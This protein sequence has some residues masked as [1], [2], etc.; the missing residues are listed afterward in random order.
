MTSSKRIKLIKKITK[1]LEKE[2]YGMID[3]TFRQFN[4]PTSETFNATKREYITHNVEDAEEHILIDLAS[5]LNATLGGSESEIKTTFWKEGFLRLFIS[6]LASDKLNAKLL[7][8]KLANYGITSFVAHPDIEPTKQWQEQIELRLRTCDALAALMVN[9]FHKSNWADQEI[10]F[11]LGRDLFVIPI[12]T[13]KDPY[14][15]MGKVQAI[16]FTEIN[17]LTTTIFKSL[18][19]NKKTNIKMSYAIMYKFEKSNSFSEAKSNFNLIE[20][21]ECWDEKLFG[22]L[23]LACDNNSQ[24]SQAFNIPKKI[25]SLITRLTKTLPY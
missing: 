25:S 18:L 2:E 3:L 6:H 5:H 10:G 15:F 11:A 14:G 8:N 22:K 24:I 7:E 4:L 23:K 16:T 12:K 20:Q 21:I 9:N 19:A 17:E 1:E 13:G